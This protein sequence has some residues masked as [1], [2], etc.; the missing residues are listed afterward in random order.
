M[1]AAKTRET[2]SENLSKIPK[3]AFLFQMLGNLAAVLLGFILASF[4][5]SFV[6]N[7]IIAFVL[8]LTGGIINSLAIRFIRTRMKTILPGFIIGYLVCMAILV[9]AGT[10]WDLLVNLWASAA[11]VFALGITRTFLSD[12]LLAGWLDRNFPKPDTDKL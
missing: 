2:M 7:G 8:A 4:T 6:M 3:E 1:S 10:N 11:F 12:D 5:F 9:W